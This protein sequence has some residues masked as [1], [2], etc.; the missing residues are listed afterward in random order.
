MSEPIKPTVYEALQAVAQDISHIGK[1]QT[2]QQQ[3]FN[4]RGIDDVL[5]A[6]HGPLAT[7]GVAFIPVDVTIV[8]DTER[9][10]KSGTSQFY[11]RAKVTY[12]IVGPAGDDIYSTVLAEAADM[13][14]KVSSKLMSMAFKYLAFQVLSIPVSGMDDADAHTPELVTAGPFVPIPAMNDH[15][16]AITVLEAA[17]EKVGK[18]LSEITDKFREQRGGLHTSELPEVPLDELKAFAAQVHEYVNR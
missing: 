15:G 1:N 17:A 18:D 11:V 5:D 13:G 8:S 9:K 12:R 4:F 16:D 3:R 10:T 14:D 2:N 7:H 6:I